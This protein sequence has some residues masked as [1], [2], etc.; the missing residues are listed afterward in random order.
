MM[1]SDGSIR[2]WGREPHDMID[3]A[4]TET[5]KWWQTEAILINRQQH[6]VREDRVCLGAHRLVAQLRRPKQEWRSHHAP[7][8][9][10]QPL[11]RE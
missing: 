8:R 9:E 2:V 11:L 1:I 5:E 4:C 3:C 6:A 10:V 7:H